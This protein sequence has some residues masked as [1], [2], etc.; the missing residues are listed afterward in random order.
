MEKRAFRRQFVESTTGF[1]ACLLLLLIPFAING[2]PFIYYDTAGYALNGGNLV[3]ALLAGASPAGTGW[4]DGVAVSLSRSPIYGIPAYMGRYYGL[5]GLIVL[6]QAGIV[7]W[8][9]TTFFRLTLQKHFATISII[10]VLCLIILSPL[11]VHAGMIMPDLW[12]GL[13]VVSIAL[14][15]AYWRDLSWL[16]R[17]LLLA[18]LLFS[19]GSH[20]SHSL[21]YMVLT[22]GGLVACVIPVLRRHLSVIGLGAAF[23][24]TVAGVVLMM[25]SYT[26]IEQYN[27]VPG[28][29]LPHLTAQMIDDGPGVRFVENHCDE[30]AFELCNHPEIV[31]NDWIEFLFRSENFL[32]ESE[33][34]EISKEDTAFLIAT[35]KAY[36]V[37]TIT[38]VLG[39]AVHQLVTFSPLD[40]ALNAHTIPFFVEKLSPREKAFVQN[41]IFYR[42]PGT[43]YV[44]HTFYW[45]AVILSTVG[46]IYLLLGRASPGGARPSPYPSKVLT[47]AAICLVGVLLNGLICGAIASP[48]GRFQ[49]R[50]IWVLFLTFA[51]LVTV[52]FR[53]RS[54][55]LKP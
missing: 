33:L 45:G 19:A 43:V 20:N 21:L 30:A 55:A 37:D 52:R 53:N 22:L 29:R 49:A 39:N 7:A 28:K 16:E 36:P 41:G 54:T 8:T 17:A 40:I 12:V 2:G 32:T 26:L 6:I 9:I 27:G 13:G 24:S 10:T 4:S 5:Y 35:F 44:A 46:I 38:H 1:G 51:L 25:A 11:G 3:A 31:P 23:V 34:V 18:M 48:Y 47:L 42:F 50:I 14:L 15:A